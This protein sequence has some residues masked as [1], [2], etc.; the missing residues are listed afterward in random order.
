VR[1]EFKVYLTVTFL[2]NY[3]KMEKEEQK[4]LSKEEIFRLFDI[5]EIIVTIVVIN[6]LLVCIGSIFLNADS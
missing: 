4:K 3:K 5:G 2:L 1:F 6:T